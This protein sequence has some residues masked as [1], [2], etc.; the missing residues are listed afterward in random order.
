MHWTKSMNHTDLMYWYA[1]HLCSIGGGVYLP[2]IYM[3][4]TRSSN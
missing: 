3:H 2:P 1:R 4:C